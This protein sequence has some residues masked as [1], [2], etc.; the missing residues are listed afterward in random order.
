MVL[1]SQLQRRVVAQ[2]NAR[3][4]IDKLGGWAVL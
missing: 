2:Q 1:E 4:G 3:E